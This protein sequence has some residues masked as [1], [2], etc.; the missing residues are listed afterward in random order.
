MEQVVSGL[1]RDVRV[2]QGPDGSEGQ[3]ELAWFGAPNGT[4]RLAMSRASSVHANIYI[5]IHMNV[6]IHR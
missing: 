1:E 5:H 4:P 6:Y 2:V 3:A